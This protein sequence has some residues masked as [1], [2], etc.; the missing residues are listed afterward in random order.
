MTDLEKEIETTIGL[1]IR[2]YSDKLIIDAFEQEKKL[3]RL[4]RE[5]YEAGQQDS[6][7]RFQKHWDQA[8]EAGILF[9]RKRILEGLPKEEKCT[10][11]QFCDQDACC[12][13]SPGFN[14]CLKQIKDLIN[15]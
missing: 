2:Y 4:I 11:G 6:A 9:E 7:Q 15:K 10:A 1:M 13:G 14:R 5:T 3:K 12:N 8:R